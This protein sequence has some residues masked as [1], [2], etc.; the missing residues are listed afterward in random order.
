[1]V[2]PI[3]S[4]LGN[5]FFS[6][7]SLGGGLR[8][9]GSEGGEKFGGASYFPLLIKAC[10]DV[11]SPQ[12]SIQGD[13]RKSGVAERIYLLLLDKNNV[14]T[15]GKHFKWGGGRLEQGRDGRGGK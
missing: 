11:T 3:R 4:H 2:L 9:R 13:S 14:G 1:M 6:E 10:G 12:G 5:L 7:G 15:P 8:G